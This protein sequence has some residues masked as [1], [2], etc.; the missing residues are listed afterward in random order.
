MKQI[1]KYILFA[2]ALLAPVTMKAQSG[3][4][5]PLIIT[6][7]KQGGGVATN[8]FVTGPNSSG[9]YTITL[10]TFATGETTLQQ[11]AVPSDIVLVL[12]LSTSMAG[13]RGETQRV[14]TKTSLSYN[15]VHNTLMSETS[16]PGYLWERAWLN[17]SNQPYLVDD[18]YY[19]GETYYETEFQYQLY[20]LEYNGEYYI[21]YIHPQ[22]GFTF[23][24]STGQEIFT[25]NTT[26]T[27]ETITP[28]SGA[29]HR[30]SQSETIVTFSPTTF[31]LTGSGTNINGTHLFTGNSR[32]RTLRE[33]L[34]DFVDAIDHN[35]AYKDDTN[36]NPRSQRLG[37]K[38]AI[39]TFE[40]NSHTVQSLVSIESGK[41][42]L[43]TAID[44]LPFQLCSGTKPAGAFD[45][46]NAQFQANPH[47]EEDVV[48]SDFLRTVVFFTDGQPDK[49]GDYR[50]YS[51]IDKAYVSKN[52][53]GANVFTVAMLNSEPASGN[54]DHNKKIWEFLNYTSSNFPNAY[55]QNPHTTPYP[56][57]G[58]DADAGYYILV[59]ES[60]TDL[61]GVFTTIAQA[62]GGAEKPIPATTQVVDVVSSSFTLP[63]GFSADNVSVSTVAAN[64]DGESWDDAHPVALTVVTSGTDYLTDETKV[65]VST[66]GGKLTIEGFEY[67]KADTDT[68]YGNWVGWRKVET[69]HNHFANKC[70]GKKLVVK[71]DIKP[72][73]GATGGVGTN[74]N[75]AGSGVFIMD[76]D[77]NYQNVN[78]YEIPHTTIPVK[79]VIQKIGLKYGESATF[80]VQRTRPKGWPDNIEYDETTK[81]PLPDGN[82]QTWTKVILTQKDAAATADVPAAER[83]PVEKTLVSLDPD[84]VYLIIEDNWG[85]A[86][87]YEDTS[88]TTSEVPNNPFTFYNKDKEG[89][90]KHAEAVS[91]NHFKEESD[92]SFKIETYKSQKLGSY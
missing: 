39:V 40:T 20:G 2:V 8:K 78:D 84:W 30:S 50:D 65:L 87:E 75:A 88:M 76:E 45:L 11:V 41:T 73:D 35:D 34:Y 4:E 27:H 58:G 33:A 23:F 68:E 54:T 85:W 16:V 24:S 51:A 42:A 32:I 36:D 13:S 29:A 91:I 46:A 63:T 52:T 17:S 83:T 71:F 77:G 82:W 89:V 56:G 62:S 1:F 61:S 18:P 55:T 26:A 86:Y 92:G 59:S 53:Y 60:N 64:E 79:L 12:D 74:T 81:K 28:P 72:K 25:G 90:V 37:N 47:G 19:G 7:A 9:L 69:S 31:D 57:D 67:S 22:R 66:S 15:D 44:L 48:G 38:V 21:Y 43:Q 80:E 6:S 70:Y 49:S 10:E 5:Q 3:E 14:T